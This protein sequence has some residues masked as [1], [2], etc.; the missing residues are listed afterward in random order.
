MSLVLLCGGQSGRKRKQGEKR[1]RKGKVGDV[2][3]EREKC[4]NIFRRCVVG[5]REKKIEKTLKMRR[6][7]E[8][9]RESEKE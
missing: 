3:R 5:A 7:K 4:T 9:E 6:T 8:R 2:R 1:E